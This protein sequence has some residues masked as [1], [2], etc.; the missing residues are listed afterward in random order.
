MR[1][2]T[3]LDGRKWRVQ[4]YRPFPTESD[5][6]DA[7]AVRGLPYASGPRSI[8][9]VN[10]GHV[11]NGFSARAVTVALP[12]L[13]E[14]TVIDLLDNSEFVPAAGLE[15][16]EDAMAPTADR[17]S[18]VPIGYHGALIPA[19]KRTCMQCHEDAGTVV[20]LA[21]E[22]RWRLRGDDGIFSFHVFEPESIGTGNLRLN[23]KLVEAGLLAHA[24]GRP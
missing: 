9:S 19:N 21:G 4:V 2:R 1:T 5:L 18:I 11:R 3:K 15:W 17:F 14:A 12:A 7:L 6:A 10:S 16:N 13:D 8:Q 24:A 20:N 23:K 22:E